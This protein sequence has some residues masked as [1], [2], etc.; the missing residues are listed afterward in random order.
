M[1]TPEDSLISN[2]SASMSPPPR[3]LLNSP[4]VDRSNNTYKQVPHF[5]YDNSQYPAV[6]NQ[7]KQYPSESRPYSSQPSASSRQPN[8][9]QSDNKPNGYTTRVL[10]RA[11]ERNTAKRQERPQ[12]ENN[13][14]SGLDSKKRIPYV[15]DSK[16]YSTSSSYQTGKSK[17]L[18]VQGQSSPPQGLQLTSYDDDY[19]S[20][21]RRPMSFVKALEMSQMV[22]QKEIQQQNRPSVSSNNT[23]RP[24]SHSQYSAS[25]HPPR[26]AASERAKTN[27]DHDNVASSQYRN[28]PRE[29]RSR[30]RDQQEKPKS[31]YD[32]T[33]EVSV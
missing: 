28:K 15:S 27:R 12:N 23:Q 11:N 16:N 32:T 20:N 3:N 25:S 6:S 10:G 19:Q 7:R 1:A 2:S 33:F 30:N 9:D 26:N 5:T 24:Y 31:V 22:E 17:T 21:T 14:I 29:P 13:P 4:G 18:P 8:Y